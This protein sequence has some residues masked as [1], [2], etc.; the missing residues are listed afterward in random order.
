MKI[1]GMVLIGMK[2][3]ICFFERKCASSSGDEKS[4]N[5]K[6]FLYSILFISTPLDEPF[7]LRSMNRF[8]TNQ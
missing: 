5:D 2:I 8:N 4:F 6:T 7:R 1:F 3:M